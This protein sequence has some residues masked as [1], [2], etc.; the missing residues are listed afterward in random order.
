MDQKYGKLCHRTATN[1]LGNLQD[2]QECVNDT[3]FAVWNTIPPQDPEPLSSYLLK[4]LRNICLMR[5]RRNR[6]E[7]R[8]GNYQECY[9]ELSGCIADST[10][11]ESIYRAK[12]LTHHIEVFLYSLS[13]TNRQLFIRR[14]WH[15]DSIREISKAT[16][17]SE[18]AVRTRL[19][20]LRQQL[21]EELLDKEVTL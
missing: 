11:P 15:M 18:S 1:I 9:E 7:K 19:A 3:Y 2:A 6:A 13:H 4:I 16:G 10:T 20:R 21:K 5:L 12:E 8:R 14:Y 17:L